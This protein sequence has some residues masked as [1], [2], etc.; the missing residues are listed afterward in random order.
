MPRNREGYDSKL[1]QGEDTK[2]DRRDAAAR[3]LGRLATGRTL[4]EDRERTAAEA[5]GRNAVRG[6]TKR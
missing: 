3:E 2:R 6:S 4:R 5:L 1:P